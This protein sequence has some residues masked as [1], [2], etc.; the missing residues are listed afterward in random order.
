MQCV[1]EAKSEP[2]IFASRMNDMSAR[3]PTHSQIKST[4]RLFLKTFISISYYLVLIVNPI[5]RILVRQQSFRHN[6]KILCHPICA[7]LYM[8]SVTTRRCKRQVWDSHMCVKH[9]NESCLTC[10]WWLCDTYEWVISH[11]WMPQIHV[12]VW[13]I[14]VIH[15]LYMNDTSHHG[16]TYVCF[17]FD[18]R[19]Q[20]SSFTYLCNTLQHPATYGEPDCAYVTARCKHAASHCNTLH[21]TE[22]LIANTQQHTAAHCDTLQHTKNSIAKTQYIL[23]SYNML[24]RTKKMIAN[25]QQ[26]IATHCNIMQN[27]KNL[28]V[29]TQHTATHCNTF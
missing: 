26:H 29:N 19:L 12:S 15:V 1:A 9:T 24:Q 8:Q 16:Q 18:T 11:V 23:A 22:D 10:E 17:F 25:W 6:L 5:K 2:Q 3:K 27:T 20:V 7:W 21:C 14:R 28:N 13:H 4:L